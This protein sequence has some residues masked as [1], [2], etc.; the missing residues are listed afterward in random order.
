MRNTLLLS[1]SCILIA[2]CST[3][4]VGIGTITPQNMLEIDSGNA[5]ESG[6]RFTQL[7]SASVMAPNQALAVDNNGDIVSVDRV[8]TVFIARV[9]PN[10]TINTGYNYVELEPIYDPENRYNA[11]NFQ[12][13]PVGGDDSIY[14]V[15]VTLQRFDGGTMPFDIYRA[16]S[17]NLIYLPT[18]T[19]QFFYFQYNGI[20]SPKENPKILGAQNLGIRLHN[21]SGATFTFDASEEYI[22]RGYWTITIKRIGRK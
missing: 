9:M 1:I 22:E 21:N 15:N 20:Y 10:S 14:E 18:T 5:N 7:N 6:L 13:Q 2:Y 16:N 17:A 8:G 12:W 19:G 3:A 11:T 4:Q